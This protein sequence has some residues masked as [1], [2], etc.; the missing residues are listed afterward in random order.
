[1]MSW[2]LLQNT[3]ILRRPRVANFADIIKIIIIFIKT[4]FKDLKKVNRITNCAPKC[5]LYLYYLYFLIYK[6]LLISGEKTQMSEELNGCVTWFI[7]F[8]DL[9]LV[10]YNC[11]KFHHCRIYVTDFREGAPFSPV[12]SWAAPKRSILNRVKVWK[13]FGIYLM[14]QHQ[15]NTT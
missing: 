11:T 12:P 6:N 2:S 7:H 5:N 15:F 13:K 8:L 4:I 9:L 1:M 10:R 14:L 3:F